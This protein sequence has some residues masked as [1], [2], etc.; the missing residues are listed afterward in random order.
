MPAYA[1]AIPATAI[2]IT[3]QQVQAGPLIVTAGNRQIAE[4]IGETQTGGFMPRI[5]KARY[6]KKA[7]EPMIRAPIKRLPIDMPKNAKNTRSKKPISNPKMTFRIIV[8]A[9]YLLV[10][11]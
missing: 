8:I 7:T 10:E 9:F 3:T 4:T 2:I 5:P 6:I 1:P 11:R